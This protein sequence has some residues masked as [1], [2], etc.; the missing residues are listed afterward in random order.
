MTWHGWPDF[1]VWIDDRNEVYGQ[2]WYEEYFSVEKTKPGWEDTL[3]KWNPDWVIVY[4][5]R[6]LAYRLAERPNDWKEVSRDHLV[7]LFRKQGGSNSRD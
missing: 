1:Q 6:P 5:E 4:A 3:T 7:V 2:A